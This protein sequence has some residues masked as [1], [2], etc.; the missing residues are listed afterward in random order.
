MLGTANF[1]AK[2]QNLA[3]CLSPSPGNFV[4]QPYMYINI[5]FG[6]IVSSHVCTD[7]RLV[8]QLRVTGPVASGI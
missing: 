1:G 3:S 5:H 4:S 7:H 2:D 8:H 6:T